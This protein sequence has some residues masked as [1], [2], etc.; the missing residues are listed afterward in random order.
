MGYEKIA[1][2][3]SQWYINDHLMQHLTAKF[4]ILNGVEAELISLNIKEL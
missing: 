3:L 1:T 2:L 4:L